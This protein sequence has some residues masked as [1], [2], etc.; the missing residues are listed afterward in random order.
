MLPADLQMSQLEMQ[1]HGAW[2]M[3]SFFHTLISKPGL[4]TN[5]STQNYV[6]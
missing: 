3:E 4:H 5:I 2:T 1:V 6:F